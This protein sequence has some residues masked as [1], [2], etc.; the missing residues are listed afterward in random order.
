MPPGIYHHPFRAYTQKAPIRIT[1]AQLKCNI[2]H[3]PLLSHTIHFH[4]HT[5]CPFIYFSHKIDFLLNISYAWRIPIHTRIAKAPSSL[6]I[7]KVRIVVTVCS[8]SSTHTLC[9]HHLGYRSPE[10]WLVTVRA[11][12]RAKIFN[13][14]TEAPFQFGKKF[15]FF[16]V[17][18]MCVW[19]CWYSGRGQNCLPPEKKTRIIIAERRPTRVLVS[20]KL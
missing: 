5:R 6:I 19:C 8:S 3:V 7:T 17:S 13:F 4:T 18:A 16:F 20:E 12:F 11:A 1:C 9:D 14:T 15:V 10:N 2:A